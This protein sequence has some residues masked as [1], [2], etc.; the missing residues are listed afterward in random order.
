MCLGRGKPWLWVFSDGRPCFH[1][2]ESRVWS[3]RSLSAWCPLTFVPRSRHC[4][5]QCEQI[6]VLG[7][8]GSAATRSPG[9]A[10]H[11]G[12]FPWQLCPGATSGECR[13][14][15]FVPIPLGKRR[16]RLRTRDGGQTDGQ[17]DG[18]PRLALPERAAGSA[19][20]SGNA[21]APE[22]PQFPL[23]KG[24]V[25]IPLSVCKELY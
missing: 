25:K 24:A 18:A 10:V 1:L 7:P 19:P 8:A 16:E 5:P 13:G 22:N 2:R 3:H 15:G 12:V 11:L 20:G 17:T 4:H 6:N 14:R 21:W 23:P 9:Q